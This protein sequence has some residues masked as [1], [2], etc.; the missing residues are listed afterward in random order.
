MKQVKEMT[1]S[2]NKTRGTKMIVVH[3]VVKGKKNRCGNPFIISETRHVG[4]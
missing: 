2:E 3:T 4:R 1:I